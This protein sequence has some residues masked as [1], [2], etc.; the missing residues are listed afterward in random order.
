MP[1]ARF[2]HSWKHGCAALVL[3]C[4]DKKYSSSIILLRNFAVC[5]KYQVKKKTDL[6][7]VY[8]G[9]CLRSECFSHLSIIPGEWV[10]SIGPCPFLIHYLSFS[11]SL[12]G[13]GGTLLTCN[14][15]FWGNHF[16]NVFPRTI[17]VRGKYLCHWVTS[18]P[19]L[20]EKADLDEMFL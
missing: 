10:G 7:K 2:H 17:V 9:T 18:L 19:C 20:K 13:E 5:H 6:K 4:V 3:F 15:S 8:F 16:I 14:V 12:H 11:F 1:L